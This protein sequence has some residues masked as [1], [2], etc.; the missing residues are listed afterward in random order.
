MNSRFTQRGKYNK[1]SFPC[2]PRDNLSYYVRGCFG[3][4]LS[5]EHPEMLYKASSIL[6]LIVHQWQPA[7]DMNSH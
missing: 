6:Y 7:M 3:G 2:R 1:V 5:I 4:K